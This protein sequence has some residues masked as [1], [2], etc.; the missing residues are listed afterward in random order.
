MQRSLR[1]YLDV[2]GFSN[3]EWGSADFTCVTRDTASIYL[4]EG[5]QGHPGTWVWLGV[6]DVEALYEE[7]KGSGAQ[8]LQPPENYAWAREMRVGLSGSESADLQCM[9]ACRRAGD[10][11]RGRGD[12]YRGTSRRLPIWSD[13]RTGCHG[14]CERR[15]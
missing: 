5:D 2:L 12:H 7:Y 13:D 15:G 10:T 8:I 1:Y 6:D 3:A 11:F 14:H 9:S 4:C